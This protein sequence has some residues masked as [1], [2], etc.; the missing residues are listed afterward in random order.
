MAGWTRWSQ[1]KSRS[2]RA[3]TELTFHVAILIPAIGG[4]AA[5]PGL[6]LSGHVSQPLARATSGTRRPDSTS[7]WIAQKRPKQGKFR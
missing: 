1:A 2:K 3:R 6:Q 4:G 5:F 7:R